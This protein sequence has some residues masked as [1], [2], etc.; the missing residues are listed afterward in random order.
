LGSTLSENGGTTLDV[1]RRIQKARGAFAKLRKV[2]Q[3]TLMTTDTNI[4]VFNACVKSVLLHGCETWLVT[5]ELRRKIQTFITR[6]IS[7]REL[8]RLPEQT[9]TNT[10]IRKRNFRWIGHTFSKDDEQSSKVALQCNPQGNRGRGRTRHSW[11]RSTPREAG[12]SL[13][14]LRYLAADPDK[15]KKPVYDLCS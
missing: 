5:N 8:W 14:E 4:K 10:E 9:D 6:T 3:S 1:S 7:N 15:W 11:R 12:R 13:S 2:W